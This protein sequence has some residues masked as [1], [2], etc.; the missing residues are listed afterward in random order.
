MCVF[1]VHGR[2]S[3][4]FELIIISFYCKIFTTSDI[5]LALCLARRVA[6]VGFGFLSL[7]FCVAHLFFQ[8]LSLLFLLVARCCYNCLEKLVV[9]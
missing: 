7:A 5:V 1:K 2:E 6:V 3:A 9:C 4:S 8:V